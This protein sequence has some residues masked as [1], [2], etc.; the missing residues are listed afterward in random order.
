MPVWNGLIDNRRKEL[1][2]TLPRSFA[3]RGKE[4]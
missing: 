4:K 2:A 1:E 3:L